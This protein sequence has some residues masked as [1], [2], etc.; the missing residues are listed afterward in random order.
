M[1]L[2]TRSDVFYLVCIWTTP[3][4]IAL[5]KWSRRDSASRSDAAEA[6]LSDSDV[7]SGDE[8]AVFT[9]VA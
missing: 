6:G 3:K 7:E 5:Y 1:Y 9:W 2:A 4:I 8:D